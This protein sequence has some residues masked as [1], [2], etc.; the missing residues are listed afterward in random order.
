MA[1]EPLEGMIYMNDRAFLD[2]NILVYCF[3]SS[4]PDKKRIALDLVL[5]LWEWGK[6]VLSLQV[7]KEFFVTVTQ[8]TVF[9]MGY[10]DARRA[11]EDF[12]C[13]EIIYEDRD[14]L[15]MAI[16]VSRDYRIS[17]WDANIITCA[18]LGGCSICY[19]EDLND[20]QI[21][22]G[23]KIINPFRN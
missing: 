17:F 8:K 4:V 18:S 19:S 20:G 1:K 2:T 22:E 15:K 23:V 7:L 12:L 9:K 10:E 3:D 14:A 6:G 16:R 5:E 21:I 11:V 13:W